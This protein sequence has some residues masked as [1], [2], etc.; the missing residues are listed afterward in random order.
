MKLISKSPR[1]ESK[2]EKAAVEV[3]TLV[4]EEKQVKINPLI[5]AMDVTIEE[6]ITASISKDGDLEKFELKG[7]VYLYINDEAKANAEV[8]LEI[9]DSK[10]IS[11]KA[12]P[13]LNRSLWNSQQILAPKQGS[14]GFPALTKLEALIYR[15]STSNPDDLPFN[16]T[17]WSSK[18][19][20]DSKLNVITVELEYNSKNKKFPNIDNIKI[21]IPLGTAKQPQVLIYIR[22]FNIR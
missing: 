3:K 11:I 22:L 20:K 17:I 10:G 16:F 4:E 6:K 9:K 18:E 15:Y 8:H 14:S 19:G 12:H 5:E 13:E 21:M 1:K 2:V 7:F